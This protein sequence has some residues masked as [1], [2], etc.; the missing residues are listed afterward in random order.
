MARM[1]SIEKIDA[2]IALRDNLLYIQWSMYDTGL[3]KE[4]ESIARTLDVVIEVIVQKIQKLEQELENLR[5][6]KENLV[7]VDFAK[8]KKLK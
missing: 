1:N 7:V 8:K 5:Q 2:L 3:E 4:Y 6:K